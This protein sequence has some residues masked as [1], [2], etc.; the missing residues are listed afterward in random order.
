MVSTQT[1]RDI[2]SRSFLVLAE[3]STAWAGNNEFTTKLVASV[4]K[5]RIDFE[6]SFKKWKRQ[7]SKEILAEEADQEKKSEVSNEIPNS[8]PEN[9]FRK[10]VI[11]YT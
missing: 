6:T 10:T 1:M 11:S 5:A 2:A 4:I 9:K 3:N 8:D 7:V